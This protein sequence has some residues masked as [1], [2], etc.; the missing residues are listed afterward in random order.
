MLVDTT[1]E[2]VNSM[3]NEL[4]PFGA[5]VYI[6]DD[7]DV[8]S[9]TRRRKINVCAYLVN[10][11]FAVY[12]EDLKRDDNLKYIQ[13]ND[14]GRELKECGSIEMFNR[15]VAN[16][17]HKKLL[18]DQRSIRLYWI[19]FWIALGAIAAGLYY[20]LEILNHFFGFYKH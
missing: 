19:N 12:R 16:N 13:L 9:L 2:D 6:A 15:F 14:R 11:G 1:T 4:A 18:Q 8:D 5:Q 7:D 20:V 10:N 17:N 3:L